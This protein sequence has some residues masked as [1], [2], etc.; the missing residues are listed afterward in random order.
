MKARHFIPCLAACMLAMLLVLSTAA[1]AD[2]SPRRVE[3]V[4]KR[5]AYAP[6]EIT[7]KKG[8]PVIL[9][10]MSTD[11]AHGISFK[12]LGLNLKIAKGKV[13]ELPLT[14]TQTGDFVGRCS[15]FCGSGHG[16][17][18]MTLHVVN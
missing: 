7:L 14:P 12:E 18:T 17:M 13:S 4:A 16:G 2:N 15:V 8:E 5:F 1:A 11:V 6:S 3:V 9:A 10:F